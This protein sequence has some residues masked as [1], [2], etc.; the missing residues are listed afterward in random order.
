MER[1]LQFYD[2]TGLQKTQDT[3]FMYI[4]STQTHTHTHFGS[5]GKNR[6]VSM[7][8]HNAH[9]WIWFG[10]VLDLDPSLFTFFW[11][12]L[13]PVEQSTKPRVINLFR[14]TGKC[15]T[16]H[17]RSVKA[18]CSYVS[19]RHHFFGGFLSWIEW[20]KSLRCLLV[21]LSPELLCAI[22]KELLIH[23]HE[24]LQSVVDEAVDGPVNTHRSRSRSRVKSS[25]TQA[26]LL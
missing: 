12:C 18:D 24:K 23:L 21:F 3:D 14:S 4:S 7:I 11:L 2:K 25:Q 1:E 5:E 13:L 19:V 15:E 10:E 9:L 17:C 16:R 6:C 22:I 8:A 20:E 26:T